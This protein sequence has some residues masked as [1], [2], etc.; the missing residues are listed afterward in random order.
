M[1]DGQ[2]DC[3]DV[4]TVTSASGGVVSQQPEG[5]N[6]NNIA[7]INNATELTKQDDLLFIVT[8]TQDLNLESEP[9]AVGDENDEELDSTFDEDAQ[10]VFL[11]A[12]SD[13]SPLI[14][15]DN[16]QRKVTIIVDLSL[17]LINV[18]N[19]LFIIRRVFSHL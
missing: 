5:D 11:I 19:Y 9:T 18:F 15:Y 4:F 16:P 6:T 7:I 13:F 12:A 17:F 1:I 14:D 2:N 8:W 3:V 10:N